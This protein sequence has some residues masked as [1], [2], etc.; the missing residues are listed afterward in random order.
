MLEI[1]RCQLSVIDRIDLTELLQ[2]L[3]TLLTTCQLSVID[4]IDLT[5]CSHR[6]DY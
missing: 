5:A 3:E 1:Y 6:C 4:R 2:R